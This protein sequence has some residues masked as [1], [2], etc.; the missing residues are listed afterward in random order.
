MISASSPLRS[1][2]VVLAAIA[3]AF[4][5]IGSCSATI[6][7]TAI[8]EYDFHVETRLTLQYTASY[9]TYLRVRPVHSPGLLLSFYRTR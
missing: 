4:A 8:C 6:C 5:L 9:M 1:H 2:R 3:A 7:T